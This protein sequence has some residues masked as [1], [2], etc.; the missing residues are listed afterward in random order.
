MRG[1]G[2]GVT[3]KWYGIEILEP[4]LGFRQ[5]TVRDLLPIPRPG[6]LSKSTGVPERRRGIAEPQIPV[7]L[8]RPTITMATANN[9]SHETSRLGNLS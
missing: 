4:S 2:V 1:F 8:C 3:G 6:K 9:V 5:F 7:F